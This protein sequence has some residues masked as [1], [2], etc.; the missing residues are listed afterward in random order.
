METLYPLPTLF[1]LSIIG[2][3]R[4]GFEDHFR[5]AWPDHVVS[6]T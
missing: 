4:K 5:L 1:Y 2:C 3:T 6:M